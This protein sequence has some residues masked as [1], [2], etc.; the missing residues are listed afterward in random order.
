MQC[1][2]TSALPTFKLFS[3]LSQFM[4]YP[5]TFYIIILHSEKSRYTCTCTCIYIHYTY[6]NA[7][8][9]ASPYISH[10]SAT[11]LIS[12]T[13][14]P[15]P[16]LY[17]PPATLSLLFLL[18]KSLLQPPRPYICCSLC[19]EFCSIRYQ[20]AHSLTAFNSW[21]KYHPIR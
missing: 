7:K 8:H 17:S 12:P 21:L 13:A 6:A 19:L 18:C 2:N 5:S 4:S 20:H 16:T 9:N 3:T 15:T 10:I 14:L 11:V 1:T